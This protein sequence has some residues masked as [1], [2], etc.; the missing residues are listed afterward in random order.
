LVTFDALT[1][2]S[3]P[4]GTNDVGLDGGDV[5]GSGVVFT[6]TDSGVVSA[7]NLTSFSDNATPPQSI[8]SATSPGYLALPKLTSLN[9]VNLNI[10]DLSHPERFTSIAGQVTITLTSGTVAMPE[11][12]ISNIF[13]IT[14]TGTGTVLTFPNVTAFIQPGLHA[15]E[16]PAIRWAG[17]NGAILDFPALK[18]ITGIADP[19]GGLY[20]STAIGISA[21][22]GTVD[23]DVLTAILVPS[24]KNG[25]QF[26]NVV[27]NGDGVQMSMG[28]YGIINATQLKS[29]ADNSGPPASS[30]TSTKV[31]YLDAPNVVTTDVAVSEAPITP[32]A[33]TINNFSTISTKAY[34]VAPFTIT[35]PAASSGLPVVVSV[36]SGPAT[37]SGN[38]V[39]ITGGGTVVL[40]ANQPGNVFYLPAPTTTTSFAVTGGPAL[41]A[42]TPALPTW[43]L[44]LLGLLLI[45][46][47]ARQISG[48]NR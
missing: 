28:N 9:G 35:A 38:L 39:T 8:L 31:G 7:P 20:D 17:K 11:S 27:V 4:A 46:M 45:A 41:A 26:N 15:Y 21:L 44:V 36:Q 1:S 25:T 2:V 34:G 47:P 12:N 43:G 48:G 10:N 37:M 19:D 22:G 3:V 13:A 29:F 40:A 14:A 24:G 6:A 16:E 5:G 33:Q 42:D 18:S 30:I 32:A 23:F